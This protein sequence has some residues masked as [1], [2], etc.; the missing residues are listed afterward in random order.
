MSKTS[1]IFLIS[2]VATLYYS[3]DKEDKFNF[4]DTQTNFEVDSVY[5]ASTDGLLVVQSTANIISDVVGYVYCDI[6]PEPDSILGKVYDNENATFPIVK[7]RYW[8]VHKRSFGDPNVTVTLEIS[9]T[10][11]DK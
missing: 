11:I 3:C 5:K 7:D 2:F 4:G 1:L 8:K 10:P 6:K 9:W